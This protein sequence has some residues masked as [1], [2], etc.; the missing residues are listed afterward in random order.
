MKISLSIL[1][2][3]TASFML[4]SCCCFINGQKQDV[5]VQTNVPDAQVFIDGMIYGTAPGIIALERD[6]SYNLEVRKEGYHPHR[7]KIDSHFS[8]WFA[9][10]FLIGGL[11][12]MI[13]DLS[14]GSCWSF[15]DIDVTLTPSGTYNATPEPAATPAPAAT[16]EPAP[17]TYAANE[18][19]ENQVIRPRQSRRTVNRKAPRTYNQP[20]QNLRQSNSDGNSDEYYAQ[21]DAGQ[22]EDYQEEPQPTFTE[23]LIENTTDRLIERAL[24][25]IF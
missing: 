7:Q 5:N 22:Y 12:G 21:D 15:S 25:K 10:N 17:E 4:N 14:T 13:I 11:V 24:D 16:P 18:N 1:T 6:E 2:V 9:G 23:R 3:L 19:Y 8:G 20:V